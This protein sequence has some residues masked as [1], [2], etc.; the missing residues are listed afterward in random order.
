MTG[1]PLTI[2]PVI[3]HLGI[4]GGEGLLQLTVRGSS[5]FD[6][7]LH[8]EVYL[9]KVIDTIGLHIWSYGGH[10]GVFH[11]SCNVSLSLQILSQA[12]PPLEDASKFTS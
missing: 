5:A 1:A 9:G 11:L 4:P 8:R 6:G 10:V 2:G 7:V 12:Q 3:Q